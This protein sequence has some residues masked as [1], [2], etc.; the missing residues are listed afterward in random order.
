M[1]DREGL[2][3]VQELLVRAGAHEQAAAIGL[4]LA[5]LGARQEGKIMIDL[6][7]GE[8]SKGVN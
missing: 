6:K 2:E 5:K 3:L 1:T 8:W 4:E 7:P